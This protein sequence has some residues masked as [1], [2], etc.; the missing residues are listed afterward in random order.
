MPSGIDPTTIDETKPEQGSAYTKDL[1]DNL[2]AVKENLATAY[3]EISQLQE[4]V[5]ALEGVGVVALV[6]R[7]INQVGHGFSVGK[8]IRLNG[9]AY[10]GANASTDADAEVI[11]I[12]STVVDDDNFNLAFIGYISGLG[13]TLTAGTVY[14][15]R[16]DGTFGASPGT[17]NKPVFIA[18][19][20]SSGYFFNY[21]GLLGAA[22]GGGDMLKTTYDTNADGVVDRAD[23]LYWGNVDGDIADQTDLQDVLDAKVSV[24]DVGTAVASDVGDF[25]TAAQGA[26]ADSAVQ[27]GDDAATLGSGTASDGQVPT[28]DGSG[29]IAWETPAAGGSGELYGPGNL[30]YLAL[31]PG[32]AS[33]IPSLALDTSPDFVTNSKDWAAD[34]TPDG[35]LSLKRVRWYCNAAATSPQIDL[36]VWDAVTQSVVGTVSN[37]TR[38]PGPGAYYVE[39]EFEAALALEAG[40]KYRLHFHT[41]NGGT[42]TFRCGS[43]AADPGI[44]GVAV[45]TGLYSASTGGGFVLQYPTT[46]LSGAYP[47]LQLDVSNDIPKGVVGPLDPADLPPIVDNAQTGTAYTLALTDAN[48][49]VTLANADPITLTVPTDATVDFPI[50]TVIALEQDDVGVVTVAPDAGVTINSYGSSLDLAG[51]W[52]TATLRKTATDT[53][54]LSGGLA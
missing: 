11:G 39:G 14:F 30:P 54:V 33:T 36:T 5:E 7:P 35:P 26:I 49:I 24:A 50:G 9:T 40:K 41:P 42:V 6:Y 31:S 27:P 19:S 23:A 17:I 15:L 34:I 12:V 48:A 46:G 18:D 13:A 45:S 10:A 47:A 52:A 20:T 25:A 3:N 43:Q 29:N 32:V 2:S 38:Y 22:G 28:A 44:E 16:D 4:N 1:R 21:R 8:P 53:W 37:V 51:Q